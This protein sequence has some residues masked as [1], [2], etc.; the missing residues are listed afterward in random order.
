M[1]GTS[2]IILKTSVEGKRWNVFLVRTKPLGNKMVDEI[3]F[4]F[5]RDTAEEVIH[6]QYHHFS[7][8]IGKKRLPT[9]YDSC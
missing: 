1:L 8:P 2:F 5:F 3:M 7:V 6:L 4:L 9:V